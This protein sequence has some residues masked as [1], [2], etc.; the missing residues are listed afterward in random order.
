MYAQNMFNLLKHITGKDTSG[1]LLNKIYTA[2]DAGD[3]GDIVVR[4]IV[5]TRDGTK[6]TIPPP[7]QPPPTKPKAATLVTEKK[8]MSPIQGA[9]ISA[10]TLTLGICAILGLGDSLGDGKKA[11]L[12]TT[13]LL[14]GG[15]GYLAVWGVAHA[16]HTPLMSVTNAI[17]GMTAVGGLLLLDKPQNNSDD[18]QAKILAMIA[19]CVS[20]VNVVGGFLVSHRMLGLFK[21]KGTEDHSYLY[22]IAG[23]VLTGVACTH[24]ELHPAVQSVC[25]VLCV[26]AIGGLAA[27]STANAGCK[28]GII[29]VF[30]SLACTFAQVGINSPTAMV[31]AALMA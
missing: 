24:T 15:A 4:S 29:G 23:F 11:A 20:A 25:G 8:T 31:G 9:V 18:S 28:F 2:I 7:P 12:L 26:M 10:F 13:F 1:T 19:I 5:T 21:K 22:L 14:A 27:M 17:S 30:S 16:L 3:Q 6:C